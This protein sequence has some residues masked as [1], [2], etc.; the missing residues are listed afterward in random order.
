[1]TRLWQNTRQVSADKFITIQAVSKSFIILKRIP[2][3]SGTMSCSRLGLLVSLLVL[4]WSF[5]ESLEDRCEPEKPFRILIKPQALDKSRQKY[6]RIRCEQNPK[7]PSKLKDITNIRILRKGKSGWERVAEIAQN[8]SDFS[9]GTDSAHYLIKNV[10][11]TRKFLDVIFNL[12]WGSFK[13]A[14]VY[15]CDFA[16]RHLDKY[17][18]GE[19][20]Q[21]MIVSDSDIPRKY[22]ECGCG[23]NGK[24]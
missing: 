17:S 21:V 20:S 22:A 23:A 1:M 6:F 14:G 7:V 10:P 8:S 24:L 18:E 11:D 2:I 13:P 3:V 9:L 5:T 19:T 12:S 15:V 16:T 4:Q